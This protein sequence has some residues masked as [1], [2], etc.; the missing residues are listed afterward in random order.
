VIW[1][2]DPDQDTLCTPP[3]SPTNEDSNLSS[4]TLQ[5]PPLSTSLTCIGP[6][7]A[8]P[9][10]IE[11]LLTHLG[12]VELVAALARL[13][14][15]EIHPIGAPPFNSVEWTMAGMYV[16]CGRAEFEAAEL[17]PGLLLAVL[18]ILQSW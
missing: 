8:Q 9:P 12:S 10:F 1:P 13:T 14:Q 6:V 18:W 4:W 7:L 11:A 15:L 17:C 3:W 16:L 5:G 2:Q